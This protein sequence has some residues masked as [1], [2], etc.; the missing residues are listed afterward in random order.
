MTFKK[1]IGK[2]GQVGCD[3]ERALLSA[4]FYFQEKNRNSVLFFLSEISRCLNVGTNWKK[5]IKHCD[6]T[7]TLGHMICNF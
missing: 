7:Q 5:K 2:T 6:Q 1:C 3:L 4:C